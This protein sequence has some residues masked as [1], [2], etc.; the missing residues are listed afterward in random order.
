MSD[1]FIDRC[2]ERNAAYAERFDQ[3]GLAAPPAGRTAIVACMD[4][5]MDIPR[6]LGLAP[7]DAHI[8]RNAGGVVTEDV[9]RSL[10]IS[11]RLLGTEEIMLLHHTDCG[12]QKFRDEELKD[13]IEADTGQRPPF[14]FATFEDLEEDVRQSMRR[15]AAAPFLVARHRIRGFVYDVRTGSLSEVRP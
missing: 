2:C 11:Q 10:V 5:R 14:D 7:G 15:L 13:R 12:M 8:L 4:A 9:V 6:I 1:T 3:G